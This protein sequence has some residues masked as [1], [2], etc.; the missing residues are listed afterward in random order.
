MTASKFTPEHRQGLLE[1]TAQGV[2]LAD[3]CRVEGL[4]LNTVKSWLHRGRQEDE[5]PYADATRP[6]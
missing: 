2:A 6:A 1:R 3:A 4:R 5:G